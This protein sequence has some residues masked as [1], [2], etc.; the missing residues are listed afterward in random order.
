MP[1]LKRQQVAAGP[2][3][4]VVSCLQGRERRGTRLPFS[5]T[6]ILAIR[7]REYSSRQFFI[8]LV[9]S[10]RMVKLLLSAPAL[11]LPLQLTKS[12]LFHLPRRSLNPGSPENHLLERCEWFDE[13]FGDDW[14]SRRSTLP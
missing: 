14:S 3:P 7:Q 9:V 10:T 4:P 5:D 2:R 12:K 8:T 1:V 6:L 13:L 11:R